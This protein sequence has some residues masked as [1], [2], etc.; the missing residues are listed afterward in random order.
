MERMLQYRSAG[1]QDTAESIPTDCNPS[2]ICQGSAPEKEQAVSSYI[3]QYLYELRAGY[4]CF[5]LKDTLSSR[6]VGTRLGGVSAQPGLWHLVGF[7][8]RESVHVKV[9]LRGIPSN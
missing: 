7:Q 1:V 5:N 2:R 9:L 6:L 4:R 3:D 8:D